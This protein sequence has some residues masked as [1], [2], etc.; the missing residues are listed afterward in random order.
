MN[1]EIDSASVLS[2]IMAIRGLLV[3]AASMFFCIGTLFLH[4][5]GADVWCRNTFQWD[6]F[7]KRDFDGDKRDEILLTND[8]GTGLLKLVP[9]KPLNCKDSTAVQWKFT[10][11]TDT[12]RNFFT[13]SDMR[14]RVGPTLDFDGDG[15][16]EMFTMQT[17]YYSLIGYDGIRLTAKTGLPSGATVGEHA[18]ASSNTLFGPI[19]DFDGDGSDEIMMISAVHLL[20]LVE[21]DG[22]S[23]TVAAE[24]GWGTTFGDW[25]LDPDF[26]AFGP[27]GDFDGD[28]SMEL[29]DLSRWGII[30]LKVKNKKIVPIIGAANGTK[31][32]DRLFDARSDRIGPAADV[33]G[34]GKAEL[35]ITGP[36]GI[37][38][39]KVQGNA[40]VP[41][42][43]APDG[44][45]LGDWIFNA[46]E[47]SFGP[48][49]DFDG[50]GKTEIIVESLRSLGILKLI[51]N[52]IVA[53]IKAKNG[54]DFGGRV[55]NAPDDRI[56]PIGDFDGD[57]KDE[58]VV[59]GSRGTCILKPSAKKIVALATA[60]EGMIINTWQLFTYN[61]RYCR[62]DFVPYP[63]RSGS[64]PPERLA[65]HDPNVLYSVFRKNLV[66]GNLNLEGMVEHKA[67]SFW[68]FNPE[69]PINRNV[70]TQHDNVD[71][72][73]PEL[74]PEACLVRMKSISKHDTAVP[75][76]SWIGG[77]D[78]YML[79]GAALALLSME[80]VDCGTLSSIGYAQNIFHALQF[81]RIPLNYD[82]IVKKKTIVSADE[83][84]CIFVG[85]VQ[86]H[87]MCVKYKFDPERR[88]I[89]KFTK[90]IA[91]SLAK[92]G[93]W[94]L[95]GFSS[96]EDVPDYTKGM[97]ARK[98]WWARQCALPYAYPLQLIV[99]EIIGKRPDISWDSTEYH[100]YCTGMIDEIPFLPDSADRADFMAAIKAARGV[101]RSLSARTTLVVSKYLE[102]SHRAILKTLGVADADLKPQKLVQ[103][104]QISLAVDSPF[105]F[106]MLCTVLKDR[107]TEAK[108][109][110]GIGASKATAVAKISGRM[111][112]LPF[113]S[114]AARNVQSM[115]DGSLN[116]ADSSSANRHLMTLA[117][118]S[119][120]VLENND[121]CTDAIK[122]LFEALVRTG[123]RNGF[124]SVIAERCRSGRN[125]NS[126]FMPP[127]GKNAPAV[128]GRI[129]ADNLLYDTSE[130]CRA[131]RVA[132]TNALDGDTSWIGIL[133]S[134][135]A[136]DSG[137]CRM[138]FGEKAEALA[139]QVMREYATGNGIDPMGIREHRLGFLL[140]C[141]LMNHWGLSNTPLTILPQYDV[142]QETII[143]NLIPAL[144]FESRSIRRM[145]RGR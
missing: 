99:A 1:T 25:K 41:I 87:R 104:R 12:C 6:S 75:D 35:L 33:N 67:G 43:S 54:D 112:F 9:N 118:A 28:G 58:L 13:W 119:T 34:D 49:G 101:T 14:E 38:I 57:G 69:F 133:K 19:G 111:N 20:S 18:F 145:Y 126:G 24:A 64:H 88:Q 77:D 59:S 48:T 107:F 76:F 105:V 32:G 21:F 95:P 136:E 11:V 79:S 23:F 140:Y 134:V 44:A 117:L 83:L 26:D 17:N 46:T 65:I 78:S 128:T 98:Q 97:V 63:D 5:A 103:G 80:A 42:A 120:V 113:A 90:P 22:K 129:I 100:L 7:K 40:F 68:E 16:T 15:K 130:H 29:V 138:F 10:V 125:S 122:G 60:A 124:Y 141:A 37:G 102:E 55:F 81:S 137:A 139:I 4:E 142:N 36:T 71:S 131:Q 51:D 144:Y 92:H 73:K 47:N 52:K 123:H 30:I 3:N 115:I 66:R 127:S 27:V 72:T 132:V 50:D 31:F 8:K 62:N 84:V 94:V 70:E 93:Y 39:L 89:E 53:V 110:G 91:E 108:A 82:M 2:R 114:A 96:L 143:D 61:F 135:C 121:L 45:L 85:L 86:Y 56:G 109:K 116:T 106:S 74:S